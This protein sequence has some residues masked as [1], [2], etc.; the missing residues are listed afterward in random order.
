MVRV[1]MGLKL[2]EARKLEIATALAA[3]FRAEFDEDM[4][5]FR[6]EAVTEFMLAQIG[7]SQYNQGI[8]DARGYLAEKINDLDVEFNEPEAT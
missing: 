7:P 5:E 4:S 6:A 8:A 1:K 3:Y 2:E